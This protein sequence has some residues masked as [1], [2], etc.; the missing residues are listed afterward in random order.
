MDKKVGVRTSV[1]STQSD[2]T[3][4]TAF[5]PYAGKSTTSDN[6]QYNG[7]S[8]LVWKGDDKQGITCFQCSRMFIIHNPTSKVVKYYIG[9]IVNT[10]CEED[11][12]DELEDI[13][14][15]EG[16]RYIGKLTTK[17]NLSALAAQ[18]EERIISFS[19]YKGR[20]RN[21]DTESFK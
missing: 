9:E 6:L 8:A 17:D 18:I 14:E 7:H 20:Y 10:P 16:E 12:Q 21:I 2:L 19:K 4:D 13:I 11:A 3:Y 5:D 15:T 1:T